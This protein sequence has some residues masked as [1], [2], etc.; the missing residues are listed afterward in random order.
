MKTSILLLLMVGTVV[1]QDS[2]HHLDGMLICDQ[3]AG[4][5]AVTEAEAK[6]LH[7][8]VEDSKVDVPA[9]QEKHVW[10]KK[11]ELCQKGQDLTDGS[12]QTEIHWT[13]SDKKRVLLTSVDGSIHVCHKVNQ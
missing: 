8:R 4:C 5:R 7:L 9:I 12:E 2:K 13:C 3:G 10:C 1:G 6:Q 11:G